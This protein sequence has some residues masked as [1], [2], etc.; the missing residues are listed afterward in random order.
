MS[1]KATYNNC[2]IEIEDINAISWGWGDYKKV[3]IDAPPDLLV[4]S[5]KSTFDHYRTHNNS[6]EL[7]LRS[8][9]DNIPAFRINYKCADWSFYYDIDGLYEMD[10]LY[11]DTFRNV[12]DPWQSLLDALRNKGKFTWSL[13]QSDSDEVPE[14]HIYP[15]SIHFNSMDMNISISNPQFRQE[16]ANLLEKVRDIIYRVK[17]IYKEFPQLSCNEGL[18]FNDGDKNYRR[19]IKC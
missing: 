15:D 14:M 11:N 5:F 12:N 16:L 18:N 4:K 17:K 2:T 10:A 19:Q 9:R 1:L 13:G 6:N 8:L 3:D 7:A